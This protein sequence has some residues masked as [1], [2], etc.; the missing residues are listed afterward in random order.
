MIR[1][2]VEPWADCEDEVLAL[3]SR[4]YEEKG[5]HDLPCNPNRALYRGVDQAGALHLVT[6]RDERRLVG[7]AIFFVLLNQHYGVP[8]AGNDFFYLAP[9]AR[10]P[11]VAQRMLALCE[12]SLRARGV[13]LMQIETLAG[14]ASFA[15]LL[16][17]RG[18]EHASEGFLRRL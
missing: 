6:V 5:R 18:F 9:E 11:R 15:R 1:F 14:D 7:F 16:R 17:G 2:A 12:N 4:F 10:R 8:W 13:V 3:G